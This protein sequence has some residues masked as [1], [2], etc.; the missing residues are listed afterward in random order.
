MRVTC[1]LHCTVLLVSC[2]TRFC[3]KIGNCLRLGS[4]GY[5]KLSCSMNWNYQIG[6][7]MNTPFIG[8]KDNIGEVFYRT[9]LFFISM[10]FVF[11][12][13]RS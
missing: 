10:G 6:L 3:T 7:D 2:F 12:Q 4:G 9:A 1:E 5:L 13:R 11:P 8:E